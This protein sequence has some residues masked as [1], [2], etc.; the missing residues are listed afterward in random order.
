MENISGD[1]IGTGINGTGNL[2]G[3]DIHYTVRGNV[4]NINSPS[5]E[6]IQELKKLLLI[7]LKLLLTKI[8]A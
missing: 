5:N 7:R 2:V 6:S 1:V 3:K 4:F 8:Q